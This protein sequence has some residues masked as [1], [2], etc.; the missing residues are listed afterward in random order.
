MAKSTKK[1]YPSKKAASEA[2][3]RK[4]KGG[5]KYKV[6]GGWRVGKK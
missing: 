6:K 4:G 3:K 2:V 1:T 5:Y